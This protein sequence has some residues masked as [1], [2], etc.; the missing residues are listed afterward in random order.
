LRLALA[1]PAKVN[2]YLH[3]LGR[4][5]DGYHRLDSLVAFAAVH[6]RIEVAPSDDLRLDL[7]GEGS[8]ALAAEPSGANLVLRAARVLAAAA[9]VEAGARIALDKRLPVAAGLGGGSADAAATLRLLDRLWRLGLGERE[10]LAIAARVGADVPVCVLGRACRVGGIGERLAPVSGV[11]SA[12]LVLVNPGRPLATAAV[13]RAHV[14]PWS[15]R[16]R[17]PAP[18]RGARDLALRLS[19]RRNDLTMAAASLEPAVAEVL[20]EIATT[21]ALLGRMSGSGATC[22]GLYAEASAAGAAADDLA[23]R[24]PAWWVKATRLLLTRPEIETVA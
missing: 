22:F 2:L 18:A 19:R 4:R 7:A 3:V 21:G 8:G 14:P 20:A 1:A 5:S 10:L 16:A 11:P 17:A 13:F 6:D 9:G 24:H 12:P 15:R 23:K